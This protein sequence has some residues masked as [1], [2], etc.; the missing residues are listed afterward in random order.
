MASGTISLLILL[1]SLTVL[2]LLSRISLKE[3]V[4][5]LRAAL[6]FHMASFLSVL[7]ESVQH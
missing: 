3:S 1:F 2:I 7:I 4:P 5:G 6:L